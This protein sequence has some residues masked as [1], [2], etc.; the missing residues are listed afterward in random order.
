MPL[1]PISSVMFYKEEFV[2]YGKRGVQLLN[3]RNLTPL[4]EQE[5]R[6]L[7]S[8]NRNRSNEILHTIISV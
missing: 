3:L 4:V 5:K 2:P 6:Q 7:L 8:N 1:M